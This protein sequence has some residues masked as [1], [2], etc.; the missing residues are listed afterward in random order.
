MIQ[1]NKRYGNLI[2][3]AFSHKAENRKKYYIC[4][5]DCGNTK[6]VREDKLSSGSVVDCG[7]V[8][9]NSKLNVRYGMLTTIKKVG[10]T[11]SGSAIYQCQCDCGNIINV[12]SYTLKHKEDCG[13]IRKAEIEQRKLYKQQEK[14]KRRL[15]RANKQP[16]L[17]QQNQRLYHI[18]IGMKKRCNCTTDSHYKNYGA[19]GIKVCD[20]WNTFEPFYQLFA[21]LTKKM[22][23]M[24]SALR[25][26]EP[27]F[28][29]VNSITMAIRV[30]QSNLPINSVLK[31]LQLL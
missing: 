4:Q 3:K 2:V 1:I 26:R 8:R 27:I 23:R 15:E 13:C 7:C 25:Q 24:F 18:Y 9:K 19:R 11:F 6:T 10:N 16:T 28:T 14:E 17:I 22:Q 30:L 31:R 20:E 12:D 21:F 5:C 29:V